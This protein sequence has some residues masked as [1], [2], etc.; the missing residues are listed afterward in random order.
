MLMTALKHAL[1]CLVGQSSGRSVSSVWALADVPQLI[2]L[3]R[4]Y[5]EHRTFVQFAYDCAKR[6]ESK[7]GEHGKAALELV[8]R[9]LAGEA[10]SDESLRAAAAEAEAA[11]SWAAANVAAHA[12]EAAADAA[13]D[14]AAVWASAWVG[15]WA[16]TEQQWQ[17]DHY[18]SLVRCPTEDEVIAAATEKRLLC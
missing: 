6:V 13:V 12:A 10:V 2:A 9:W 1:V 5:V 8:R 7:M 18:R 14:A 4:V 17:A 11:W 16:A 15:L 3:S